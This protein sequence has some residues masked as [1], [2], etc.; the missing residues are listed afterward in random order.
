[1]KNLK[2]G[3]QLKNDG[4]LEYALTSCIGVLML[5][6]RFLG[7]G[8]KP[9]MDDW[10]LYGDLYSTVSER[11]SQFAVPNEKFA[12]RPAAG[13]FDCFVNAPLFKHLWLVE[14]IL[15]LALLIGMFFI[16]RTLRKNNASGAE[17]LMC[18]V[19]LYPVTFEATYWIAAATRVCYSIFFIGTAIY[20]LDYY[21]KTNKKLGIVIFSVLGL[22]STGFYEPAIVIYVIL[23]AFIVWNNHKT[24]KDFMPLLILAA[25][26][27]IIGIY[28]I[29][30]S[31]TGEIESRGGFV[32]SNIFE[33]ISV[34]GKYIYN[35]FTNL[36]VSIMKLGFKKGLLA[37]WS[38]HRI[39]K[40]GFILVV[41][42]LSGAASA[43]YV[44]KR[45]FSVKLFVLGVLLFLGGISLN[46]ALGSDRI[47]LRLVFFSFIGAGIIMDELIALLPKTAGK[48]SCGILISCI[49]FVFTV[50]GIGEV[51]DFRQTSEFDVHITQQILDL[52]PEGNVSN[53]DKNTYVFGGQHYYEES[54]C[55]GYF[56]HIR[57]ASGN[58][59]DI[60]GCMRHLTGTPYT[61]NILTFTYGDTQYV[62]P[63]FDTEGLCSFYNIEYDKTVI[64]ADVIEDGDSYRV[65]R[66]D[67]SLAGT[68][69]SVDGKQ[70]RF[71]N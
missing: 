28:Y 18:L 31:G 59:A 11:M 1:M 48:I 66:P 4:F 5:V 53:P 49:A 57:G 29:A 20:S 16:L 3:K 15:T 38:G 41:S 42:V 19:C 2:I 44:K 6:Q 54:K 43:L 22:I 55:I 25:Q 34:V 17:F 23:T 32:T 61:N 39:I 50:A 35:I 71:F 13:F 46:F 7:G 56:D 10:F 70:Y 27:I 33:H 14:L 60:T 26:L 12:I 64:K 40:T 65:V 68:L 21:F 37:I 67:G 30:N 63:Y 47:T 45:K 52:D 69:V 24:K 51:Q 58:Y 36:S 9:V 8:Y 62:K